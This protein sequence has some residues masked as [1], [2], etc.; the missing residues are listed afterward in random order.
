MEANVSVK[1]FNIAGQIQKYDYNALENRLVSAELDDE[2]IASFK[3]ENG[4]VVFTLDLSEL[5]GGG[6]YGNIVLSTSTMTV[7]EGETGTFNI[8]L[9]SAPSQ[10]QPVYIAVSDSSKISV[11]PAQVTFTSQNYNVAQTITVTAL[12][13]ADA[14]DESETVAVTS[15]RVAAKQVSVT[16]TDVT[17]GKVTSGLQLEWDFRNLGDQTTTVVDTVSGVTLQNLTT[18]D[19]YRAS[20]GINRNSSSY[21][22][23][24]LDTSADEF[25]AFRTAMSSGTAMTFECFGTRLPNTFDTGTAKFSGASSSVGYSAGTYATGAPA[26]GISKMPYLDSNSDSHDLT[27]IRTS[28]FDNGTSNGYIT[29][30]Q[31]DILQLDAVCN[32]NGTIDVY[33]NGFKNRTTFEAPQDFA[34]WDFQK[35]FTPSSNNFLGSYQLDANEGCYLTFVRFYN[36]ALTPEDIAKNINYNKYSIGISNFEFAVN[37]VVMTPGDTFTAAT[38]VSPTFIQKPAYTLTS[39]SGS[40]ASVSGPTIT[41]VANGDT[42][43]SMSATVGNQSFTDSLAV[44]VKNLS[45]SGLTQGRMINDITFARIPTTMEIGEEFSVQAY[46][47]NAVTAQK[48]NKYQYSDAN[49][50]YFTS[51]NP[52]I[53][54]VK[55]G[56]LLAKAIGSATI[57]AQDIDN[58]VSKSFSVTVTAKEELSFIPSEVYNVPTIDTTDTESTTTGIAAALTYASQNGYKKVVFPEGTYY[59]SPVYGTILIPTGMI[60]DF[61]GSVIQIVESTLTNSGYQMFKFSGTRLSKIINATIYGER[62]LMDHTGVESC[63]SVKFS[64]NCY[65]SGLEN[66]IVSRSPGFNVT[67]GFE[68]RRVVGCR[69]N[70]IEAG[71]LDASGQPVNADYCWRTNDY[72]NISSLGDWFGFGNMQGYQGYLYL[73]ARVYDICFY[74]AEKNFISRL[75]NCIQYYHYPRPANAK[76][77]K[78]DFFWETIPTT[79]DP[80][81]SS[82]AHLYTMDKPVNCYVRNCIFEDCYST[83]IVPNAGD[84]FLIENCTFKDNGYR[85]PA[86]QIDWE[87]GRNNIK[88][89][90]VRNNEFIR[91]GWVNIVGGDGIVNHNNIYNECCVKNGAEAQNSRYWLNQFI[92][93]RESTINCKTDT[94]FSQNVGALNASYTVTVPES[95]NFSVRQ[96]ENSF[97][98]A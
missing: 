59:V 25:S 95:V 19:F 21:K 85:D 36:R 54:S 38:Q 97:G 88:G 20:N 60:V 41:G 94:V 71:G 11:S 28:I 64:G 2:G 3:N 4:V 77:V 89:H 1:G 87:D 9:E 61:N 46:C 35:A 67:V 27:N 48:A 8:R 72:I 7:T 18:E 70:I 51:S 53:I 93:N 45:Y 98:N 33:L 34:S 30:E 74:D 55:N 65:K 82:I 23:A 15:R 37:G 68:N 29:K 90:I 96:T 66:C 91:G 75:D 31:Q 58:T 81:Y 73:S 39:A 10:D 62:F 56:V 42:T 84:N 57:T 63:V 78:I 69:L 32:A 49:L 14:D 24:R 43:V 26:V 17:P 83:A 5:E 52:S 12:S 92:G 13:D 44:T 47:L 16:I 79:K 22:Y 50:V 40:V 80:D 86:S 6:T 76:Y